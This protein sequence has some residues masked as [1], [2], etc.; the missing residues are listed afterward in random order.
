MAKGH[1]SAKCLRHSAQTQIINILAA[2][3]CVFVFLLLCIMFAFL[4]FSLLTVRC[5]LS[6]QQTR[7]FCNV[8]RFVAS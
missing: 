4:T 3:D 8:I 6:C 2:K 7:F 5:S 1:K